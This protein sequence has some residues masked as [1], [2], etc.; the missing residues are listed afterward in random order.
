M[1]D[2]KPNYISSQ[3]NIKNKKTNCSIKRQRMSDKIKK[4]KTTIWVHE[5]L[6]LNINYGNCLHEKAGT[7]LLISD[8][9]DFKSRNTI[10]DKKELFIMMKEHMGQKMENSPIFGY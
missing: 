9:T 5:K 8:Q 10:T 7:V 3:L 4:K 6:T 1:A 2:L